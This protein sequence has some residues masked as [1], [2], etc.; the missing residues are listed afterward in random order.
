LPTHVI[1]LAAGQGKRMKSDLPK[2]AH[3]VAGRPLI[4][5]VGAAVGPSRPESLVVV[6]GH[7]ADLVRPLLPEN[8]IVAIQ[9]EQLGTGHATQIGLDALVSVDDEDTVVVLYGDMPLL[10]PDLV[11]SLADRPADTN[12]LMVTSDFG[13]PSGYGRVIRR[14]GSVVG[15]VEDRDCDPEQ[16]TITEINAGVYAF[17]AADLIDTLARVGT[18]NAQGE[19]YLTDV[20]GLLAAEGATLEA[21]KADSEE[22]V[23]I[24]SQDQLADASRTLQQRINQTHLK[25][26]VQ[27]I[28][29]DRTYIDAT[30]EIAVGAIIY[31]GVHLEGSTSIGENTQVGP[32][33]FARDSVIGAD[34]LVWYSVLRSAVVGSRCE[35]GPYAS[36]RAGTVLA[37]RAKVGTFVETKNAI[38]GEGAKAPHLTYLGD[39]TIGRGTN[40]GAGT[41]TCNFDGYEKHATT[42]GD[43]V[44]IGSDTMLVAPLTIGDRAITGAGSAITKDVEADALAVERSDQ[45][46][47]P[48]YARRRAERQAAKKV[49][50]Q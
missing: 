10:T 29:P 46:T 39:A 31:P 23:G 16:A 20:I 47:I 43:D 17:R 40:I 9:E 50:E 35:V 33:V 36:L 32:D 38:L 11:R 3:T 45:K 4:G 41:I 5:W 21:V 2:V 26:G 24:N 34:S 6:L 7:G 30:V 28:D 12:A 37:D 18:N 48:G 19:Q 42:I 49:E 44:F 1:V 13:D 27:I 14:N 8:A 22:V 15:I 25:A